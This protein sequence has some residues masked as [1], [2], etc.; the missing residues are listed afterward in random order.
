MSL[1]GNPQLGISVWFSRLGSSNEPGNS[2][3]SGQ[4]LNER[5]DGI[6]M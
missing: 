3:G 4:R 5:V 6:L 2:R 1:V